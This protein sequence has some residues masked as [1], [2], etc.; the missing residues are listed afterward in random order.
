MISMLGCRHLNDAMLV[1]GGV[2]DGK[3]G[4]VGS[5]WGATDVLPSPI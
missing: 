3:E 4:T 1:T 5:G 2:R